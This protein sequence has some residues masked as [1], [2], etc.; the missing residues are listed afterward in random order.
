MIEL[1]KFEKKK[2]KKK[3]KSYF[4]Y[5]FNNLIFNSFLPF[6]TLK[7]FLLRLFGAEIGRNVIIK[8]Y[9]KIKYP[10]NLKIYDNCWIGE[11][12]WID[13]LADVVIKK[14]CCIYTNNFAFAI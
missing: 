14:N 1:E 11:E 4:W 12:V 8:P 7:V 9:V 2:N 5:L 10:W 3:I 6:S 13:N